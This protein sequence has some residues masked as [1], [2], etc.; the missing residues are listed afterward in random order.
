[1]ERRGA[2]LDVPHHVPHREL[3]DR[4]RRQAK[5]QRGLRLV[6]HPR[7]EPREH[8]RTTRSSPTPR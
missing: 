4:S 6:D 5:E 2:I 7:D 1:M 3:P 8:E